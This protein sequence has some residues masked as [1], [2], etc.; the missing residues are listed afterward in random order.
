MGV[1]LQVFVGAARDPLEA[2]TQLA[3]GLHADFEVITA[4]AACI[5]AVSLVILRTAKREAPVGAPLRAAE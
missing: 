4:L 5:L 1:L 2:R 3:A